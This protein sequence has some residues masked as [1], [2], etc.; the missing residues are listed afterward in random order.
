MDIRNN[1]FSNSHHFAQKGLI[2]DGNVT[3]HNRN[4]LIGRNGAGKTRFLKALEQYYKDSNPNAS[5]LTLYFPESHS[6]R[7]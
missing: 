1:T 4:L 7:E 6:N 5:V 3:F 2:F